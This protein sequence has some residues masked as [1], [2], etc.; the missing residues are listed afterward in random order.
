MTGRSVIL[1]NVTFTHG[2][3][4]SDGDYKAILRPDSYSAV[5]V[6]VGFRNTV[7]KLNVGAE[8]VS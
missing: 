4:E 5:D 6:I 1:C 3:V 7:F 8:D 2:P